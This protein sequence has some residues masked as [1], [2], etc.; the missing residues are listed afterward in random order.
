MPQIKSV[1]AAT[2]THTHHQSVP[3]DTGFVNEGS[4]SVGLTNSGPSIWA[5]GVCPLPPNRPDPTS[6]RHTSFKPVRILHLVGLPNK[7]STRKF[8]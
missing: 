7:F 4:I 6:F 1:P 3:G 5:A 8:K 2:S